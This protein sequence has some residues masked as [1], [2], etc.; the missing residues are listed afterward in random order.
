L[1]SKVIHYVEIAVGVIGG[2]KNK[3]TEGTVK[4]ATYSKFSPDGDKKDDLIR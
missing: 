3:V 1:T 4:I 2:F